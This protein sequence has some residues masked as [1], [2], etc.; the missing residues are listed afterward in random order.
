MVNNIRQLKTICE[1]HEAR[2]LSQPEHPLISLIDYSKIK[3]INH[4]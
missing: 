4:R 2:K 3:P 1:F